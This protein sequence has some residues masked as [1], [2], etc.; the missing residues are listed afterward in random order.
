MTPQTVLSDTDRVFHTFDLVGVGLGPFNLGLAALAQPLVDSGELS[1]VF[2]DKRPGFAWH[3]GMM[4]EESTIQV[5]FLAD[6][7]TMAD[8]TSEYSFLNFLKH[9]GR[10]HQFYIRENFFPLRREYSQ[11]CAWVNSRLSTTHW[12]TEVLAVSPAPA[13]LRE[14]TGARW[15]LDLSDGRQVLARHVVNGVGTE[16]FAPPELSGALRATD[17]PRAVHSADYLSARGFLRKA[18]SVTVIG[19]GQSAAEIYADLLPAAVAGGRRV[20]WL[21]RSPRF[22]PME[23]TKLTLE[24][25][26]PEY[27][28]YVRRLPTPARDDLNVSNR[29]LYKGI[30]AETINHIYD[31]LYRLSL[32]HDLAAHTTLRAGVSVRYSRTVDGHLEFDLAH[33]ETGT[34]ATRRTHAA[35]L[36]TGYRSPQIPAFLEPCRAMLNLDAQGRFDLNEDFAADDESTLFALN[37]DEHLI[38]LNG[39]DL[40]MGPWRNSIVL[41]AITGREVYPVERAIAFQDFGG[42]AS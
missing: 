31:M 19:S 20:D 33:E 32:D 38:S 27:A 15:L 40:G 42:F 13:I 1:A 29:A 41:R 14:R 9:S 23:Y 22:F 37:A 34:R 7:V 35:V 4:L 17:S 39:P 12:G 5:P 24:M 18:E 21:T 6:L 11:Y 16:P 2:F 8:P 26:S 36:C 10:L 28:R 30:S 25:T 3:P